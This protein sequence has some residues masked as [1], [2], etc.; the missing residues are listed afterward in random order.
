MAITFTTTIL[1]AEGLNATG[2]RIPPDIIAA[3]GPQKR[4]KLKVT[5]NGYTYRSTV[6]VYSGDVFTLPLS[7]ENREAAGVQAGDQVD[8][9]LELDTEPRTVEVPEDLRAALSEKSG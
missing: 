3:L 2:L 8:V 5:L 7:Q 9:T 4:P 6:A 1:Q